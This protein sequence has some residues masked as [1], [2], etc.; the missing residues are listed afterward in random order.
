MK[1][2]V[3]LGLIVAVILVVSLAAISYEENIG[4]YVGNH[5]NQLPQFTLILSSSNE[6]VTQ[7][8]SV[9][10]NV[11]VNYVSGRRAN[12][13]LAAAVN[14]TGLESR[15][16]N[17][18][19]EAGFSTILTINVSNSASTNYYVINVTASNGVINQSAQFKLGVLSSQILV[20]CDVIFDASI[21]RGPYTMTFWDVSKPPYNVRSS[22]TLGPDYTCT[23]L[24]NN[25]D[26]YYVTLD[27]TQVPPAFMGLHSYAV[28]ADL[29]NFQVS[30]PV[31]QTYQI[32]NFTILS[33]SP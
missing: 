1:R 19:G 25:G 15:F 24:L 6:T 22:N 3:W 21:T 28:R 16:E 30:A 23:Q 31:G 18:S 5:E 27:Y 29:G 11:T 32:Q 7:G 10:I 26:N 8:K 13:T 20:V 33:V 9:Q 14:A 4:N 12:V 17:S 2:K